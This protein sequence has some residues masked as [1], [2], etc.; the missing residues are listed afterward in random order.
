MHRFNLSVI[1]VKTKWTSILMLVLMGATWGLQVA[2]LKLALGPAY[3]EQ[4]VILYT[5]ILVGLAYFVILL[6]RKGLF[7]FNKSHIVFFMVTSILGYLIP[8]GATLFASRELP[9]GL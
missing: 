1:A 2:M 6:V 9:A 8:M 7:G 4:Q 5:L 3:N